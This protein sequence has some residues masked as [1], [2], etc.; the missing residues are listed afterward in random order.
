MENMK[1]KFAYVF[2][3]QASQ[4]MGMCREFLEEYPPAGEMFETASEVLGVDLKRVC[5]EGPEDVLV[6]TKYTQP[7]LYVHSCIANRFLY[8]QGISP[9]CAAGHSLGEISALTSAGS[10]SYED[11]LRIVAERSR[12]MQEDCDNNPGAMAAVMGLDIRKVEE[13][14]D[15]IDGIVQP[16]NF[17]SPIQIVV[18]GEREAVELF[19]QKAKEAGAKR[20]VKLA[21]GGAYHSPLMNS[22]PKRLSAMLE[23]MEFNPPKFPVIANVTGEAYQADHQIADYLVRQIQ[24]PVLWSPSVE[25]MLG[26]GIDTFVEVGPGQVLQG[27]IKRSAKGAKLLSFEKPDD[28]AFLREALQLTE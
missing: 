15:S 8:E 9:G 17:N 14:C 12:A 5:L 22:T 6:Q 13:I 16:A 7:A 1:H 26:L 19:M 10:I 20:T 4:Y 18:S 25:Y 11:G 28:F 3:G 2:P 24:S 27:L 21:V 23:R